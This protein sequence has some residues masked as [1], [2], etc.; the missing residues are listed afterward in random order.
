MAPKKTRTSRT[1][2]LAQLGGMAT[3]QAAMHVGT[4]TANKFRTDERAAAALEARNIEMAE[5]LVTV[6]GTM[7]GA[8]Q[9]LGQMLSMLD[10]GLIPSSHREEFQAKLAALQDN[11]PKVPW[12]KMRKQIEGELGTSLAEAFRSFD[13]TPVAAASIGQVY[14]AVTHDGRDVAVKVQ[15]PGIATAVRADLKNLS[16]FVRVY[17]KFLH[18]G[19]DAK[20]LAAELEARITEELD[21][22][23]EAENTR[24]VGR[25]FRDH[26]FIRIPSVV[27]ELSTERVLTTEWIDGK[28]LS[29]AYDADLATRNRIA[30]ILFRFYSG[31]PYRLHMYS[32][33]PHP[34]NALVLPDGRMAFLDFGLFKRFDPAAAEA[35]LAIY[36]SAVAGDGEELRRV[37]HE[38]GFVPDSEGTDVDELVDVARTAGWW[39]L[40]DEEL[41]ITSRRVNKMA[42][43]FADPRSSY[44]KFAQKQNLPA[45]HA[46]RARADA[47]LIA[48]VGQLNPTINLHR[49]A[50]EWIYGEP[51]VTDLGRQQLA[52]EQEAGHVVPA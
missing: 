23:L 3:G 35:E 25:A 50:R 45:E 52:W 20:Q 46:F 14:R 29:S 1:G 33:D 48:I 24:T 51:P 9:K 47:H 19:L 7:K 15:Y 13:E 49:V 6:L 2:R 10:G 31:S 44:Y 28:P 21:Y 27:G 11:A 17:G 4:R 41:E 18:E 34:G 16:L 5:R 8:A 12:P 37:L 32:G 39:F 38:I 36:R 42:A 40:S 43:K 26:P 22:V 30:E